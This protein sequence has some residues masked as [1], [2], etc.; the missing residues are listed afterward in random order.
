MILTRYNTYD[1]RG[2]NILQV[3]FFGASFNEKKL[4]KK[5]NKF[6]KEKKGQIEVVDIKWKWFLEHF[7]LL[8]Y[9]EKE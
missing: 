2:G 3:K 7:V 6:L 5:V 1:R 4:E 8:I 9:K